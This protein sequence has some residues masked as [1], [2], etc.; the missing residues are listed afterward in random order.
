MQPGITNW[1]AAHPA[2]KTCCEPVRL[3]P[4]SVCR[5]QGQR[6]SSQADAG[7]SCGIRLRRGLGQR[8]H[9]GQGKE[10]Q[11]KKWGQE[12]QSIWWCCCSSCTQRQRLFKELQEGH[13]RP[14]TCCLTFRRGNKRSCLILCQWEGPK[15]MH[16]SCAIGTITNGQDPRERSCIM[17]V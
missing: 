11:T 7:C 12:G 8:R 15:Q 4:L 10:E 5:K 14:S 6:A 13:P 16:K 3:C 1:L 9:Q 17:F 2:S